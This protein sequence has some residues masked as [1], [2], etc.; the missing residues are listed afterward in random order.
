M[1]LPN[2][3]DESWL[4]DV[5]VAHAPALGFTGPV[6]S[7]RLLDA[8]LT[9]PHRPESPLCRGWATCV[10]TPRVGAPVQFYVKGFP[11]GDVS[12]EAWRRDRS[13]R[14][15]GRSVRLAGLDVV[16]WPFPDDPRLP[17]VPLLVDPRRVVD[18]LPPRVREVLGAGEPRTTVVRY[19]PE[20]SITLRLEGDGDGRSAVFAKHLT[21]GEVA[22]AGARHEAIWAAALGDDRLRVAEPLAT[23]DDLGVLWTRGVPGLPL[24][25]AVPPSGLVDLADDVGRALAVLHGTPT[26][27]PLLTVDALLT[28][29]DKKAAKLSRAHPGVGA[30]VNGMVTAA[31]GRRT[32]ASDDTVVTLHGDFHLDQLVASSA[33]PVLVD[34]DSMVRGVPEVDLAEFLVDLALRALPD[35]V[36][37]GVGSGLLTSYAEASGHEIDQALLETC[38]DA[39]FVNRCYRHLR[40][41][42]N[43]WQEALTTELARHA[44]VVALLRG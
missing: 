39:E 31:A 13:T 3:A 44:D 12:E 14:P 35:D 18:V 2:L 6:H 20:A 22:A 40:R 25:T 43:W 15:G 21:D 16:V 28:E 30:T 4:A 7:V 27:A 23:D 11:D 33:G 36:V 38:A 10:V 29:M 5:V 1:W 24:T 19:Q 34:L 26:D 37:H 41:H 8:R 32:F 17:A 9:H 42:A